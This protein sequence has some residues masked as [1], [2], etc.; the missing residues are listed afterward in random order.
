MLARSGRDQ[1]IAQMQT[2]RRHHIDDVDFRIVYDA[3]HRLVTVDVLLGE[4]VI[5]GIA[6]PLAFGVTGHD[7]AQFTQFRLPQR[8][9]K[10]VAR[11]GSHADQCDAELASLGQQVARTCL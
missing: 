7:A 1:H 10:L 2:R 11:V 4:T 9:G 5:R 3:V 8:R 6:S